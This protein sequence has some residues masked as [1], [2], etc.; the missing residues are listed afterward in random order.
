MYFLRWIMLNTWGFTLLFAKS[1]MFA[2]TYQFFD[3][4]A[5]DERLGQWGN[6]VFILG[7][8]LCLDA[9]INKFISKKSVNTFLNLET[10][11][12]ETRVFIYLPLGHVAILHMD[13]VYGF[14]Y[15]HTMN[16]VGGGLLLYA[17]IE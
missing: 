16:I 7:L 12:K 15:F 2:L 6:L 17:W 4:V 8:N 1:V 5:E 9:V 10:V 11:L 3:D 13:I 14:A